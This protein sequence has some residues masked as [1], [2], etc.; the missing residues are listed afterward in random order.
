M[1]KCE[2]ELYGR[3]EVPI[4][5][6]S[7]S[8]LRRGGVLPAMRTSLA[9]PDRSCFSVDLYPMVTAVVMSVDRQLEMRKL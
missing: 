3:L 9:F 7:S 4:L 5:L 1:V 8:L 6:H 2:Y